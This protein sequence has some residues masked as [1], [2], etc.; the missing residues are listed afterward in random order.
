MGY[1]IAVRCRSKKLR[2][3]MFEFM[4][5][6]YHK[7]SE[8]FNNLKYDSSRLVLDEN[9]AYDDSKCSIGFN[10]NCLDTTEYH[11]IYCILNW[12][13]LNVGRLRFFTV[14]CASVPYIVYDGDEAWALLRRSEWENKTPLNWQWTLVDEF[15]FKSCKRTGFNQKIYQVFAALFKRSINKQDKIV[16]NELKRLNRLWQQLV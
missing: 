3:M 9:M 4:Q 7:P 5:T 8:I 6:N 10:Y 14:L 2:N 15:G 16:R 12:M 13:A 11:Y 1:T